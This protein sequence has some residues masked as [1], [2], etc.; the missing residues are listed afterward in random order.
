MGDNRSALTTRINLTTEEH[1]TADSKLYLGYIIIGTIIVVNSLLYLVP[2]LSL[3]PNNIHIYVKQI[4]QRPKTFISENRILSFF[5]G[6]GLFML[7]FSFYM[8]QGGA[9]NF[10]FPIAVS[11]SRLHFTVD[12]AVIL[13]VLYHLA[14]AFSRFLAILFLRCIP[15]DVFFNAN[16]IITVVVGALWAFIG[17]TN[18]LAYWVLGPMVSLFFTHSYSLS[19]AYGNLYIR[20]TGK[21]A[22]ILESGLATSMFVTTW[23]TAAIFDFMGPKWVLIEFWVCMC[24]GCSASLLMF[25]IGNYYQRKSDDASEMHP[26]FMPLKETGNCSQDE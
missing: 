16:M 2:L 9:E 12:D 24:L 26:L 3:K 4:D 13:T 1:Q 25:L 5:I 19:L 18:R 10:L 22:A 15:L 17:L 14:L 11:V 7:A 6:T 8:V 21:M 20:V 23:G